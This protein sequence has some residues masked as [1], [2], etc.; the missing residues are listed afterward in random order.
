MATLTIKLTGVGLCYF[1][2]KI[3]NWRVFIPKI[4]QG[5][6]FSVSIIKRK[7]GNDPSIIPLSFQVGSKLEVF[8]T[9]MPNTVKEED[10][11]LGETL[12]ID[13]LHNEPIH[14]VSEIDKYA[15]FVN[16]KGFS[17]FSDKSSQKR[18]YNIWKVKGDSK[19]RLENEYN[20]YKDIITDPIE[21]NSNSE[22]I[23]L[24]NGKEI[25]KIQ[26]VDDSS[27]EIVFSNACREDHAQENIPSDFM[28]YYNI[29][30]WKKLNDTCMYELTP[31][32]TK[33]D[34]VGC[35]L[36]KTKNLILPEKLQVYLGDS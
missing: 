14:L 21:V 35:D 7:S 2:E 13:S 23:L 12:D 24:A 9:E 17:L 16:L 36:S 28:Y 30:N 27:Y 26:H 11:L 8:N 34:Y 31:I 22:T 18:F 29:I 5:H 10:S 32:P 33:C 19:N 25:Y 1:D 15:A 6:D 20:S 3:S 4:K